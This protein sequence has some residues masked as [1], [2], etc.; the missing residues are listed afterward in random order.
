MTDGSST[1]LCEKFAMKMSVPT[2]LVG[3][4]RESIEVEVH[5]KERNDVSD[6]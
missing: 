1:R 2:E 3:M 4:V 6:G 5:G